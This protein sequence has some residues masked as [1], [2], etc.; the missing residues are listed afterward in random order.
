MRASGTEA[1]RVLFICN[2]GWFFISHRLA[3]AKS[4]TA[5]GYAVHVAS[6]I[7]SPEEVEAIEAA[8]ISFHRIRVSRGGLN[9]LK[10][11]KSL[12]AM[13]SVIRALRPEIVHNVSIK[14]V[15]Y[16]TIAARVAGI[17][18]IVNAIS[19]LGWVFMESDER[20]PLRVLVEMMYRI[21]FAD[22]RVRAIFQN[23][24]DR[25][26]F[27]R[28]GLVQLQRT[29][30]IRGSGVDLHRFA[31]TAEIASEV[32]KITLP[33][34]ML[35]DKGVVEFVRAA[36]MLRDEGHDVVCQLAGGL[37][38]D[39]PAALTRDDL[40]SMVSTG[41]VTWLGHVSD[42]FQL[43]VSSHIVCLPS[44]REGLPKSLLE[45]CAVGRAI[46]TT[47][48]PGC[49]DVVSNGVNGLLV[50]RGQV[51]ELFEALKFLVENPAVRHNMGQQGRRIAEREFGLESV[52]DRTLALYAELLGDPATR[53]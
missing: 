51:M 2:V 10:D 50:P 19:G 18:A 34:R 15:L 31:L 47:N 5:A 11:L 52:V 20:R 45:A 28:T 32:T 44:Y 53:A 29:V 27:V 24:D 21:A 7:D 1:P 25:T 3:L 35:K 37:D 17:S 46:V 16:G 4:I 42:V 6:D 49:R 12:A 13:L 43:M 9:P 41:A 22:Q 26:H 23:E 33:G 8:G 38:T 30:L 36:Q 40:H 39:N 48:V 14:P